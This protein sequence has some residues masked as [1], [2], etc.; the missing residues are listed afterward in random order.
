MTISDSSVLLIFSRCF[1]QALT[2]L[3]LHANGIGKCGIQDLSNVLKNN[4]VESLYLKYDFH[5]SVQTIIT[6]GLGYNQIGDQ[7]ARYLVDA[8]TS[9]MVSHDTYQYYFY[10]STQ[11][12]Q[13]L[14]LDKNNISE[15]I[16]HQFPKK[17]NQS[18]HFLYFIF[19]VCI[20][21]IIPVLGTRNA[22]NLQRR[23]V[24][25]HE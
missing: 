12:L 6:L 20:N 9:N 15:G 5:F 1:I 4:K 25:T 19:V 3:D 8:F 17:D 10:F 2:T 24:Q 21:E 7:E 16:R 22:P 13:H 11:T 14:Y 23:L 18:T